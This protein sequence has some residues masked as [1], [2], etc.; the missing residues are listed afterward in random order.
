MFLLIGK[1]SAQ[2]TISAKNA[3]KYIGETVSVCDKV[4]SGK[5]LTASNITLLDLGGYNPNQALTIMIPAADRDKFHGKPEV[6]YS[7]KDVTV[8]GEIVMYKGKPEIVVTS[9]KHLK[10]VLIDNA[11]SRLLPVKPKP[12]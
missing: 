7:G 6:D 4:F 8:M 11:R 9:P 2:K 3:A 1:T 5:L 12:L 10:L